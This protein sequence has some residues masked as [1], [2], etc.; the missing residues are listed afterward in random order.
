M[1]TVPLVPNKNAPVEFVVI[2]VPFIVAV[3]L[4]LKVIRLV[5][6]FEVEPDA[7]V[8]DFEAAKVIALLPVVKRLPGLILPTLTFPVTLDAVIA[9][10]CEAP[11]TSICIIYIEVMVGSGRE[12]V[13]RLRI[14]INI[15]KNT[16][17]CSRS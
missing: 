6:A 10:L 1:F 17:R 15:V 8:N 2:N 9:A 3:A 4:V 7:T 16:S 14:G 5:P 11:G 12:K 13:N